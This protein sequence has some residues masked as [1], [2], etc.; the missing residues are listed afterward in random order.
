MIRKVLAKLF[1]RYLE[2]KA[3]L[4]DGTPTEG[5]PW[6]RS[7]TVLSGIVVVLRA[8]Y[9]GVSQ[10]MVSAGKPALPAIPPSFDAVL[11]IVLGTATIQGR[12]SANQPITISSDVSPK[13]QS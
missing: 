13:N 6:F 11:G 10:I 4:Y 5:K 2:N 7:K 12:I 3:G 9:E 8:L 1:G